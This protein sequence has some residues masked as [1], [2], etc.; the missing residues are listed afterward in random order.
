MDDLVAR[1]TEALDELLHEYG[2][3]IHA[4]AYLIVRDASDAEEVTADTLIAAWRK[5]HT[6][7]DPQRLR[8]WLLQIAARQALRR[9]TRRSPLRSVPLDE[10]AELPSRHSKVSVDR[11]VLAEALD[12]LPPRMRAVVALHHVAGLSVPE[13]AHAVGRSQNTVKSQLRDAMVKL[14]S[15]LTDERPATSQS[16][17]EK[18]L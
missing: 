9:R 10:A 1:R 13:T 5:I 16:A 15:E 2:R 4:V 17:Q 7:R 12:R 6:L 8:S 11:I 3:E 18:S 14:R